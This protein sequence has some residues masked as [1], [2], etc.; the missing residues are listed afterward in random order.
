[1]DMKRILVSLLFL[2]AILLPASAQ[3]KFT[4]N[5]QMPLPDNMH[6]YMNLDSGLDGRFVFM[7]PV[8]WIFPDGPCDVSQAEALVDE[9]GLNGPLKDYVGM[10]VAVTGPVN[11][12]EYDKEKDFAAYEALFNK[13]RVFTNLKVVGIGSGA[14][15]VNEVIAPVA[16]EV[17]GIF[18]YG[19]KA[20]RKT[21]GTSTVPAY[22]AGKD[23]TKSAKAYIAR[24]KAVQTVKGKALHVYQ[25]A[26]EPLLQVIVNTQKGLSLQEAFADAWERLL[27]RNYRCSNLGHTGYMGGLLGQY[28][29]YELEPYLVWERLGTERMKVEQS[30]FNYNGGEHPYLWYEYI[31]ACLKDASPA[32]VPLVILLHGHNNDP[33]TQAETSGFVELGASEGFFVAELEWQ[34]KP[35]YEYMDD[36][37]IE[38]VVRELLRKYP[39]LDPSRVYAEGL[40]AGGFSA[41]AL[42]VGKSHLF[43]AVGAHS[44]GV[45]GQGLNL[46]FPFMN[47]E[48][49]WNEA[50]QKSGK[51]RMP[52]FSIC[53]TADDAVP[54]NAPGAHNGSM[55]TDSWR[56]YQLLNG[57]AV[58][59]PTD[60]EKYPLFGLE[61]KNRRRLE[62]NKHHA[63]EV[64]DIL[65]AAQLPVIRIVAV[66][67]FGHWNFV[68]GT[69]LMWDF[70]KH[71]RRDPATGESVYSEL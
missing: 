11:G 63:M 46:G 31:P 15:F 55:I 17:A 59:G 45:F 27:S 50:R 25:N 1:M 4:P 64:G 18:C 10:M 23:A 52:F 61:L 13:I 22:L 38:A 26:D 34:G 60:L 33:R 3:I 53:G 71:W 16:G 32:S 58:S 69:A 20:P 6:L 57:L 24:D 7:S 2:A 37:G 67:N 56:L 49:L 54:F 43:A 12:K 62:T 40:S 70:F 29:D 36:N 65:D 51:I 28:G 5:P 39:Q 44:G 66:E 19:G 14:T 35:G 68:P 21:T 48:M 41:T 8:W 47:P 30:L 42:G 9:L